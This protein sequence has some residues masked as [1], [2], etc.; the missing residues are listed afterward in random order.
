MHCAT[1]DELKRDNNWEGL[2]LQKA[3]KT[4]PFRCLDNAVMSIFTFL[5]VLL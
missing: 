4:S 3:L 5:I 2:E 1:R